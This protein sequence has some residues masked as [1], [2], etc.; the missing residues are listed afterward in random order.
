[1]VKLLDKKQARKLYELQLGKVSDSQWYRTV[2][3]FDANLPLTTD[4]VRM[5]AQIKKELPKVNLQ[6][7]KIVSDLKETRNYITHQGYMLTGQEFLTLLEK[8]SIQIHRN[9]LYN[10]F[11]RCGGFNLK[12]TYR[13]S[14][15]W[16]I[17]IQAHTHGL[18]TQIKEFGVNGLI[19]D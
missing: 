9:T 17:L 1:M 2:K 10:W 18:R 16:I 12:R 4:N 6:S 15:I 14:D 7:V 13:L 5:I 19:L 3:V 8:Y 11:K